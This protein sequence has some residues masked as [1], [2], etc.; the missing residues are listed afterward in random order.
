MTKYTFTFTREV[1]KRFNEIL[2]RL[3]EDEYNILEPIRT[4]VDDRDPRCDDKTCI[5]EMDTEACLTIR[6]GLGNSVKIRRE[7]TEDE[8]KEE[9]ELRAKNTVKVTVYTGSG[10]ASSGA[11]ASVIIP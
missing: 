1:E 9:E 7:R 5:I 10:G 11:A 6:M 8:L 3:E 2:G 4:V